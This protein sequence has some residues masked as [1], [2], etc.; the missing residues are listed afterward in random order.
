MTRDRIAPHTVSRMSRALIVSAFVALVLLAVGSESLAGRSDTTRPAG[1]S[2]SGLS[3]HILFTRAGGAYGDETLFVAHADGSGE[4]RISKLGGSCCPSATPTGSR[5]ATAANSPDGRVT[6][7]ISRLDGTH[8]VMLPLPN[9]TLNLGPGPLSADGKTIA[10]EGFDEKHPGASG[11]YLTRVSDGKIV[12]RITRRQFIVADFSP[13]GKQLLLFKNPEGDPPPPGALWLVNTNGTGLHRLTRATIQVGCCF[14]YRWSP[15]GT[16]ILFA[17]ADGV[18]WTIAPN[19]TG[20]TQVFKDAEGRYAITPTWSPDGS[21]IMFALDP[22]DDQ[23]AHPANGLYVI[24]ADGSDLTLVLG[25]NNF[26]RE[27][28]WVSG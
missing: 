25:G 3:G 14:N 4:R 7:A 12:R 24:R 21:V 8:R 16:K 10:R 28:V 17:D 5:V 9:G 26:K 22:T 13:N 1:R 6:A 15:D 20:L 23:F 27:P 11:V 18:L 2:I 19:G